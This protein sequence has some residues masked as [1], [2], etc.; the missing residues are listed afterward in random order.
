MKKTI[1]EKNEVSTAECN[2]GYENLLLSSDVLGSPKNMGGAK[3]PSYCT[4]LNIHYPLIELNISY[5]CILP[6]F[7]LPATSSSNIKKRSTSIQ[8]KNKVEDQS[9]KEM[10]QD[11][12]TNS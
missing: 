8:K 10:K 2:G 4:H 11:P 3:P 7:L 12:L 5:Q 1:P 6:Y 9:Q